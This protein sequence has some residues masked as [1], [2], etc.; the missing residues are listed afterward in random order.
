MCQLCRG[1][2]KV[3]AEVGKEIKS[4][5]HRLIKKFPI[6]KI[7]LYGSFSRGDFHQGSDVDLIVVGD[8]KGR[9]FDRIGLVLNEYKGK[10]D[11]EPLVYTNEEFKRMIKEKRPFIH[12]I[13]K[14]GI[15]VY[16]QF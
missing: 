2:N 7:I 16:E 3:S 4:L 14:S 1:D 9:F 12:S 13:L 6:S 11:L 5:V 15:V 10:Y 8:F